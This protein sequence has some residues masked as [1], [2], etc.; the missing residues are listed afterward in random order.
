MLRGLA[1]ALA[2]TPALYL[3]DEQGP[4]ATVEEALALRVEGFFFAQQMQAARCD[5]LLR[6]AGLPNTPSQGDIHFSVLRRHGNPISAQKRIVARY[7][8]RMYGSRWGEY[9][10]RRIA[11]LAELISRQLATEPGQCGPHADELMRRLEADWPTML[12]RI[13]YVPDEPRR[14]PD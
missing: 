6:K 12:R 8:R 5:A 3:A 1:I 4:H 10:A 9:E 11:D 7:W 2:L 13:Q 14:T